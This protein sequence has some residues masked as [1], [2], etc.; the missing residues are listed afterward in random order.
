MVSAWA[1]ERRLVLG[2][3]KTG[4]K[5]NEITALPVLLELLEL[6]GR[7][8]T[9]AA[10]GCQTAVAAQIVCKRLKAGWD[11]SYMLKVLNI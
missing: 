11:E 3:L 7:V 9:V 10:V 5:S 6:G 1:S 4:G 2:Q 8:V